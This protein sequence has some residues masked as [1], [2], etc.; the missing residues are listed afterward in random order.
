MRS[1]AP[2][3]PPQWLCAHAAHFVGTH[4]SLFTETILEEREQN[5]R[6]LRESAADGAGAGADGAGGSSGGEAGG[7]S[8]A[9]AA[10]AAAQ[11]RALVEPLYF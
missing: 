10:A 8:E 7:G 1:R 11:P 2:H 6:G 3:W 4:T 5:G 9:A